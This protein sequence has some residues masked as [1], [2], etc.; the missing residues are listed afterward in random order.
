[1]DSLPNGAFYLYAFLQLLDSM[2]QFIDAVAKSQRYGSNQYANNHGLHNRYIR[3]LV[4]RL[5]IVFKSPRTMIH[6]LLGMC[7]RTYPNVFLLP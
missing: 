1:M 3:H 4:K 5:P 6:L 7:H 2:I